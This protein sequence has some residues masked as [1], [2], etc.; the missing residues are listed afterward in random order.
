MATRRPA[1]RRSENDLQDLVD[2]SEDI[3]EELE[4]LRSDIR[5]I[6]WLAWINVIFLA[7]VV[8]GAILIVLAGT[9]EGG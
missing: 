2:V 7:L 4:T 3:L 6:I 5:P 8:I 1:R 9:S